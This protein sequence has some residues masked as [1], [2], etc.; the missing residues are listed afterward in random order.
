[1]LY[2]GVLFCRSTSAWLRLYYEYYGRVCELWNIP[3]IMEE[4]LRVNKHEKM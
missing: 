2:Q 3:I 1:M 4:M